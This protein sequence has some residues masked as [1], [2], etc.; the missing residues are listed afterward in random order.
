LWLFSSDYGADAALASMVVGGHSFNGCI[1]FVERSAQPVK[2]VEWQRHSVFA[3][4][5]HYY[6]LGLR[7]VT[8][9]ILSNLTFDGGVVCG[10]HR[11]L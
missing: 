8:H 11:T 10:C 3:V 7:A 1:E 5:H 9:V 6:N 2:L 4:L